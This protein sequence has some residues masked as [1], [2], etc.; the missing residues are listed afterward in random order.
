MRTEAFRPRS[1][2]LQHEEAAGPRRAFHRLW[3]LCVHGW[4]QTRAPRTQS[5]SC[6][7]RSRS[8]HPAHGD[9]ELGGAAG[10]AAQSKVVSVREDFCPEAGLPEPRVGV[11]LGVLGVRPREGAEAPGAGSDVCLRVLFGPR[12][13]ARSFLFVFCSDQFMACFSGYQT[14]SPPITNSLS[15][16]FK[17]I[18][19]EFIGSTAYPHPSSNNIN[20]VLCGVLARS[21]HG[22]CVYTPRAGA[23]LTC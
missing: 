13:S 20:I 6:W 16:P 11:A 19:M 7:C 12:I 17:Y 10:P 14:Q 8:Q 2:Q 15:C 18:G 22:L 4:S 21:G 1:R 5:W 23:D 9:R 3:E